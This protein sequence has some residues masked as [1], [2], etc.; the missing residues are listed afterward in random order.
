MIITGLGLVFLMS[1]WQSTGIELYSLPLPQKKIDL[2]SVSVF[3]I[4]YSA[5]NIIP[6]HAF[7]LLRVFGLQQIFQKDE[8]VEGRTEGTQ[9]LITSGIYGIVRHP[10]YTLTIAAFAVAPRMTL[11]R[12]WVV[13]LCLAYLS[14]GIPIEE[15]KCIKTF[16]Q[17]YLNYREKAPA[18]FPRMSFLQKS[19]KDYRKKMKSI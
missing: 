19:L 6:L 17:A 15:R 5:G 18:I 1:C 9:K 14:F 8:D 12:L 7:G 10:M 2:I 16:G 4:L 3:T 11:D 13:V